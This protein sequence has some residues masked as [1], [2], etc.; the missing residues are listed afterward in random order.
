MFSCMH[1][2]TTQLKGWNIDGRPDKLKAMSRHVFKNNTTHLN[3]QN[4]ATREQPAR[5]R[6][7][8]PRYSG[9]ASL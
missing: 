5:Q 6:R 1:I 4:N 8:Q 3:K 2:V 9:V 7:E